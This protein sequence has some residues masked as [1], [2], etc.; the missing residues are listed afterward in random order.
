MVWDP[1]LSDLHSEVN[2]EIDKRLARLDDCDLSE[3][4]RDFVDGQI[5]RLHLFGDRF[6]LSSLQ[7]EQI[8]RMEKRY[9]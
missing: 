4:D 8:E 5:K 6:S 9:L 2:V 3:W 1:D 7:E